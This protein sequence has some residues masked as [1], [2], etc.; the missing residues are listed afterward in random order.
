MEDSM[1]QQGQVEKAQRVLLE[2]AVSW[3]I[4]VLLVLAVVRE[5]REGKDLLGIRGN[6]DLL[7][8]RGNKDLLALA[9]IKEILAILVL[10]VV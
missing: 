2:I 3:E 7:E 1:D 8:I 10:A 5:I 6:K 9:V 4:P